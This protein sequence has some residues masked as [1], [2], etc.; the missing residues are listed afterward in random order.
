MYIR[1]CVSR[2]VSKGI[3]ID[4]YEYLRA[5]C[6]LRT[7]LRSSRVVDN[8]VQSDYG[9]ALRARLPSLRGIRFNEADTTD[10]ALLAPPPYSTRRDIY[11]YKQRT[12]RC[13][14]A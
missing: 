12:T 3:K 4:E 9:T 11:L 10:S 8:F 6:K 2:F 1:V 13:T 7:T 5:E 14:F